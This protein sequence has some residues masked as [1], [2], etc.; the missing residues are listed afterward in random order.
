MSRLRDI[1]GKHLIKIFNNFGFSI[2]GQKGSHVKMSRIYHGVVQTLVI[3]N[4]I[5]ISKGTLKTI[6]S[7]ALT[8]IPEGKLKKFFYS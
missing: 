1:S 8:Y 7:Q 4:H 5:S 2:I 6:Y 3:P